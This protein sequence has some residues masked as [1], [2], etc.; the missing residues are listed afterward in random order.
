[1]KVIADIGRFEGMCLQD[2]AVTVGMF[3]GVHLGHRDV[4][5][6]LLDAKR[7][8]QKT[9]SILLTFDRHPLSVTHPEAMPLLLTT[10]G[11]KLS[12]LEQSGI[13]Y[14][15]VVPFS[16]E[17][18]SIDYRSFIRET[19]IGRLGM[20]H[21]VIGYDFHLGSGREG[22]R[23][24][25]IEASEA[26]GFDITIVPPVVSG[27]RVVSSTAIRK[28]LSERKLGV[29][30]RFLGRRYFFDAEVVRGEGLGKQIGFPTANLSI[31]DPHKLLPPPGVY[32]VQVERRDDY[33]GGM[34]NVGSAPTLHRDGTM[35]IEVHVFGFGDRLY[36]ELLRVHC[37]ETIRNEK[38]FAGADQLKAQ[39]LLDREKVL[40]ILEKKD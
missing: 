7:R 14:V 8:D 34:M 40:R 33:L 29:A 31:S 22:S 17:T 23:E 11:E 20:Q 28:A 25:L 30:A 12:L 35:R 2:T 10:L 39:L 9:A 13:D 16:R 1:M 38:Q 24:R 5:R 18:A 32:A 27:G 15:I 6:Q 21:L 4:I 37:V 3:D 26:E 19:L 36:G